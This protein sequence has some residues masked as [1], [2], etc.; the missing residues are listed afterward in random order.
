MT[1]DFSRSQIESIINGL[2]DEIDMFR[3]MLKNLN[4]EIKPEMVC[5]WKDGQCH[6]PA[7][8]IEKGTS[9]CA[10]HHGVSDDW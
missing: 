9:L 7:V 10:E 8:I 4:E 5:G 2:L 1:G 3:D 6:K